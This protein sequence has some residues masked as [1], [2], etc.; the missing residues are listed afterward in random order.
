MG[1]IAVLPFYVFMVV[2]PKAKLVSNIININNFVVL[3]ILKKDKTFN[4]KN[5]NFEISS[6]RKY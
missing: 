3:T 2:A 1:T 6:Q 5:N 4:L